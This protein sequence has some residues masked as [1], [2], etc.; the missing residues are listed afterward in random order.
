MQRGFYTSMSHREF[1]EQLLAEAKRDNK[2]S[3]YVE[4]LEA[5]RKMYADLS[6]SWGYR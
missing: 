1:L 6:K 3:D 2:P 4:Q 5:L